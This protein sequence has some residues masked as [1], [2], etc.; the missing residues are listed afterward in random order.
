MAWYV[1]HFCYNYWR[2]LVGVGLLAFIAMTLVWGYFGWHTIGHLI[3]QQCS[4]M[5]GTT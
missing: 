2:C 3:W 1:A 4:N 5:K